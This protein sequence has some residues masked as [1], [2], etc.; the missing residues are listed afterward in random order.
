[1]PTAEF[2]LL[3]V[4]DFPAAFQVELTDWLNGGDLHQANSTSDRSWSDAQP[5]MSDL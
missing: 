5:S 3:L 2:V 1:M 4:A